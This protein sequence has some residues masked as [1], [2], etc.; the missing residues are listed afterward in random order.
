MKKTFLF[1]AA[2]LTTLSLS[3]GP[4]SGW[5]VIQQN[6]ITKNPTAL[7]HDAK[8]TTMTGVKGAKWRIFRASNPINAAKGQ[9]L[10]ITLKASG[11]GKIDIG[12]YEYVEKFTSTGY[13]VKKI[14][15]PAKLT[16]QKIIIPIKNVSTKIVRP[17]FE[18]QPDSQIVIHKIDFKVVSAAKK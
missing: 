14:A 1:A 5:F 10:E 2:L 16:E 11:K 9:N 18:V 13:N 17:A 6:V 12:C 7:K 15:I 3:A 8:T 4:L